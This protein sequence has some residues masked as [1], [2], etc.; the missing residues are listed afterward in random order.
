MLKVNVFL[1]RKSGTTLQQFST[2]WKA[3]HGP[4][5][6]QQPEVIENTRRYIQL[7]STGNG[8]PGVPVAPYDGIAE[9]WVDDLNGVTAIFTS[10][11]YNNIITPDEE[12]FLDREKTVIM[13]GT[14]IVVV[15]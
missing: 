6:M 13:Y 12:N 10:D 11:N 9:I 8:L 4:L 1:T 7:H 2:Y 15:E 14:E 5:L 3:I